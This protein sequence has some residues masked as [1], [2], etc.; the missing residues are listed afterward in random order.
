[1]LRKK[2]LYS[3]FFLFSL[4]Y[5]L[6]GSIYA[7]P[8]ISILRWVGSLLL[9]G[10]ISIYARKYVIC[11]PRNLLILI[12]ALIPSFLGI[13]GDAVF[14][15]YERIVSLFLVL[16]GL[17]TFFMAEQISIEN[18]YRMFEI[19]TCIT[20]IL[21]IL[22]LFEGFSLEK[23]MTGVYPNP[24]FLS[25]IALFSTIASFTMFYLI[26]TKR[27]WLY[28]GFFFAAILC[29]VGSGSRMGIVCIIIIIYSIPL[30]SAKR[31]TLKKIAM[32]LLVMILITIFIIYIF[33]HFEIS[34]IDRLLYEG[35][36][37]LGNTGVFRSDV[38]SDVFTIFKEKPVFGWGYAIVGYKTFVV[39]D[40]L[41]NWGMH[42]S[43]FVIL[44][45]M[46]LVGSILFLAFF[47]TLER[48][49]YK[50]Y[51]TIK[52]KTYKQK[53]FVKFLALCCFI[54]LLNAYSE[55][56]LFSVGNPMSICFWL[57]FILLFCY[58]RKLNIYQNKKE[59]E[60]KGISLNVKY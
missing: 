1:M 53:C 25:C 9:L 45:E 40:T 16:I 46:G 28:M 42:S 13:G 32:Q 56:F 37:T 38:W 14:Y 39:Q 7:L 18:I 47:V 57:P 15:A 17:F 8:Y 50:G 3:S 52:R 20:G 2:I 21:M 22:S 60:L 12:I 34:A 27:R 49:I 4:F 5:L 19:Y 44:C 10:A 59:G 58:V 36:D 6:T 48:K 24:N 26:E 51:K 33:S 35:T 54:M 11:F 41:Y 29:S 43:Y 30:I 23:R 31:H 55:S